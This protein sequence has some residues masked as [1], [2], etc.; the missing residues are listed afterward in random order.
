MVCGGE[1]N[2]VWQE[3]GGVAAPFLLKKPPLPLE[4]DSGGNVPLFRGRGR[5]GG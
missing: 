3:G 5:G 4:G 2:K 1:G